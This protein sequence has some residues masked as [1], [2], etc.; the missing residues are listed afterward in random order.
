MEQLNH[1]F[2]HQLCP[3]A[4]DMVPYLDEAELDERWSFVGFKK[5]R[6]LY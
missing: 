5:Q 4:I 3:S 2:L 1:P 6:W